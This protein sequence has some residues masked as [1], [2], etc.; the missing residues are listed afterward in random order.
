MKEALE[1]HKKEHGEH[2]FHNLD[3]EFWLDE[4]DWITLARM[5]ILFI[6][7]MKRKKIVPRFRAVWENLSQFLYFLIRN[8]T[9]LYPTEKEVDCS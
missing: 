3:L 8:D 1:Q 9:M 4:I 7:Q 5:S 2:R 6:I